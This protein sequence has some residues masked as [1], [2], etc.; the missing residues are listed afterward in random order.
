LM[1]NNGGECL[2]QI[3]RASPKHL[4]SWNDFVSK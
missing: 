3:G 2:G 4:K 1:R